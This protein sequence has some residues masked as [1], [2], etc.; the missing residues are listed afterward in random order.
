[1]GNLKTELRRLLQ[2][3]WRYRWPGVL[4]CWLVCAA[5]WTMV[6]FIPNQY[7]SSARI[8]VDTDA[9]LTP[10]LHGLAVDTNSASQMDML[11][12]TLL[13]RPNLDR[14][15]S[16]TDLELQL[17]GPSD[18]QRMIETLGTQIRIS[19]AT[20]NLFSITYRNPSP[21]L[22]YDVVRTVVATFVESKQGTNRND[23]ENAAKF[24]NEQIASYERQ[25]QDAEKRRAE[26]RTR[27]IDLLPPDGG[28]I[29]KL[30][31]QT[32][33]VR[34]L[35]GQLQDALLRR[36]SLNKELAATP[37]ML[38]TE[39][40]GGP[41]GS[42]S[43][44]REAEAR[45]AELRLKFTEQNPDV[46]A[47]RN[48]VASLRS[49]AIRDD[50]GR[51]PAPGR[52]RQAP[53]P[54]YAQLKERLVE[55]DATIASLQRQVSEGAKEQERLQEIARGAP[56]LQAEFTNMN[57]DY[58][59]LR[60]NYEDLIARRESMRISRAADSDADKVKVQVIDPPQ[61][62]RLPVAPNRLLLISA[63]L[64][65]GVAAGGG[66]AFLLG[67]LD[68]SFHSTDDLRGLGLP[69][70]GG[71]SILAAGKPFGRRLLAVACFGLAALVPAAAYVGL[72][73]KLVRTPN[74]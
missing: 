6:Y 71:I 36:E 31:A 2:A 48:L 19:S 29:S 3:C 44:L 54:I 56:G 17:S 41:A 58:D 51:A 22:A 28:G 12:R 1:M 60:K 47:A 14:L 57:R 64:A 30:E 11:Q 70:V 24:L 27:Y 53:N 35:Q 13:S 4:F 55:L 66:L 67:Q 5:G 61:V 49:G 72:V 7:E 62:S 68:Q 40:D 73:L 52:T 63:V 69:V 9:I 42:S 20:R 59:V 50:S 33:Q 16:K 38:V 45:L 37:P 8:Y 15:I 43:R 32:Q 23:L 21:R 10:L 26:F 46:I 65:L 18:R 34:L 74:I 25:L 39:S